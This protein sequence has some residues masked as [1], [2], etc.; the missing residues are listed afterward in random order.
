V[1][2]SISSFLKISNQ[3][4]GC[5]CGGAAQQPAG[6]AGNHGLYK[7]S[8]GWLNISAMAAA[9]A[10]AAALIGIWLASKSQL[11]RPPLNLA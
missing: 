6:S 7:G 2:I 4:P 11:C 9:N 3:Q 5:S 1:T 10:A 8:Y